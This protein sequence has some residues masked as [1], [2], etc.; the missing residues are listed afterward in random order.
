MKVLRLVGYKSGYGRVLEKVSSRA[1][2]HHLFEAFFSVGT[3]DDQIVLPGY[4]IV[5]QG[6]TRYES[7]L[8]Q[9]EA[10]INVV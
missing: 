2:E 7:C 8:D 9:F 1:T 6:F 5:Q 3:C 4:G 10:C